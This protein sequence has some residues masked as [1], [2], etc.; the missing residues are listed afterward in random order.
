MP[1]LLLRDSDQKVMSNLSENCSNVKRL[2]LGSAQFGLNY[3]IANQ[4]GKVAADD[5]AAILSVARSQ[6][7]NTIDTAIAYGDS[8]ARLGAMGVSDWHL[9]S[10]LPAVPE[11]ET[12]V[13]AWVFQQVEGSLKRLNVRRLYGLLLHRPEQ[14]LGNQGELIWRA[15]EE[16]KARGLTSKTGASIYDPEELPKILNRFRLDLVQ[17]PLSILDRRMIDSGWV[18][19]LNGLGIELH[20]RSCFLQGLL[21]MHR[22]NRPEKFHRWQAVWDQFDEWLLRTGHS[23]L[24]AC[25]QYVL[26]IPEVSKVVVGVDSLTQLREI[27]LAC[28]VD[29]HVYPEWNIPLAPELLNPACWGEL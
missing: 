17:A 11:D 24:Q 16:V 29:G 6:G 19:K 2:A 1:K 9:V 3:G 14:L 15:L 18:T 22:D 26:S 21:L 23:P 4:G 8:E 13:S 27:L 10:K 12:D 20:T 28:K 7:L 25:L 5:A